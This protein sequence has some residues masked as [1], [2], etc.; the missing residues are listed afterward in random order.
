MA[1]CHYCGLSGFD[2]DKI[3]GHIEGRHG[4]SPAQHA[5]L[6]RRARLPDSV[7]T[8]LDDPAR[9]TELIAERRRHRRLDGGYL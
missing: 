3:G 9:L 7:S 1:D 4:I 5:T 8:L 6:R 2:A